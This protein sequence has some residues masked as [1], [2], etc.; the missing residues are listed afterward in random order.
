MEGVFKSKR[1]EEAKKQDYSKIQ[2]YRQKIKT[3]FGKSLTWILRHGAVD[4]GLNISTGGYVLC[5][6]ILN[7]PQFRKFTLYDIKNAVYNSNKK[8]YVLMKKIKNCIL[9][10]SW[11]IQV[12]Y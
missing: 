2:L 10:Q 5:S 4:C 7:L 8:R 3:D 11:V 1:L 6:S 12:K 9:K